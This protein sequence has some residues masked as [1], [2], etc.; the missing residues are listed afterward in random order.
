MIE[1]L[2]GVP[3]GRIYLVCHHSKCFLIRTTRQST[4]DNINTCTGRGRGRGRRRSPHLVSTRWASSTSHGNM[5]VISFPD[6]ETWYV[7]SPMS[8]WSP[9]ISIMMPRNSFSTST[10]CSVRRE[11]GRGRERRRA[12]ESESGGGGREGERGTYD[13]KESGVKRCSGMGNRIGVDRIGLISQLLL[14]D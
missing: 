12:G 14:P 13:K 1:Q 7:G 6:A 9:R 11:Q 3:P 10:S 2:I 4:H 8:S 5:H